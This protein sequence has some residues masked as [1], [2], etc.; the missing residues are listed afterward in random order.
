M[1][2]DDFVNRAHDLDLSPDAQVG[3]LRLSRDSGV[4][5]AIGALGDYFGGSVDRQAILIVLDDEEKGYL[6][7]TDAYEFFPAFNR[8]FGDSIRAFVPG[9]AIPAARGAQ[10]HPGPAGMIKLVCP[11]SPCPRSPAYV[12]TYDEWDPLVCDMHGQAFRPLP[13]NDEE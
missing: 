8:G 4:E 12:A 1:N 13:P 7:R 10:E 9:V 6:E 2:L 3:S 11:V 5:P